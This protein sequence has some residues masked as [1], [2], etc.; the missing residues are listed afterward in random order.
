M[1]LITRFC[2][3]PD[4]RVVIEQLA[5]VGAL[6]DRLITAHDLLSRLLVTMRL[7]APGADLPTPATRALIAKALALPDW[8][9]VVAAFEETRQEVGRAWAQITER[10]D[11]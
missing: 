4:L 8:D 1:Q 10:H 3:D 5:A 2:F 7:V 6:P 9:A 11:G